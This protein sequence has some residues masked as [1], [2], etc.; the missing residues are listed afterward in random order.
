MG[1]GLGVTLRRENLIS[2]KINQGKREVTESSLL[3]K[4]SP[5][6]RRVSQAHDREMVA[7]GH[8]LAF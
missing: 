2:R 3:T 1:R 4:G 6:C 5:F 7:H 8:G